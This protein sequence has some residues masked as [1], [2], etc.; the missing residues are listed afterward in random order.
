MKTGDLVHVTADNYYFGLGIIV[1]LEF[2]MF[3]LSSPRDKVKTYKVMTSDGKILHYWQD[4][5]K[6]LDSCNEARAGL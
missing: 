2:D 6:T 4:E 1:E 3:D 5:L